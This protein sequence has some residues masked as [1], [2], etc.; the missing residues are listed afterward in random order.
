MV[1]RFGDEPGGAPELDD[2]HQ[3][4]PAHHGRADVP[5]DRHLVDPSLFNIELAASKYR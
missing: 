1:M 2:H 5:A 3:D 4:R